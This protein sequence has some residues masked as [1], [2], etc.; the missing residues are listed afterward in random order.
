MGVDFSACTESLFVQRHPHPASPLKG[1]EKE[2]GALIRGSPVS[3][4]TVV[5]LRGFIRSARAI[6]PS[7]RKT[8]FCETLSI[9]SLVAHHAV[10]QCLLARLVQRIDGGRPRS[11][12]QVNRCADRRR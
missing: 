6:W 1:E 12:G 2:G 10:D 3:L 7:S 11:R 4:T 9:T 5:A 8:S